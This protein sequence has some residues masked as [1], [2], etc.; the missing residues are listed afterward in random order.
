[1]EVYNIGVVAIHFDRLAF[2]GL[3]NQTFKLE[4]NISLVC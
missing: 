4:T 2:S 3:I 1:M